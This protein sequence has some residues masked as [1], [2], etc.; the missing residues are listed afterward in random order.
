MSVSINSSVVLGTPDFKTVDIIPQDVARALQVYL[1]R[2]SKLT[3]VSLDDI[4][5][6]LVKRIDDQKKVTLVELLGAGMKIFD[7]I[8]WLTAGRPTTHPLTVDSALSE[9]N[10]TSLHEV[11]RAVFYCYFF[12]ITQARYPVRSNAI[13]EPKTPAFL[14]NLLGMTEKQYHYVNIVCSFEPEKF[15]KSWV[16]YV[17]FKDFGQESLSRFGLGVAGYRLFGPFKLYKPE[18]T[19][20]ESLQAAVDF[21]TKISKSPPT[22]GIHPTTRDPSV[23]TKRGNLNKNLSNLIL[24]V[25]TE[26]QID[27]MVSTKIL[28]QKPSREPNSRNYLQWSRDDDIS[29]NDLIFRN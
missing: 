17:N 25:Y 24:D 22:W 21:A 3:G 20:D 29:G 7:A 15:D 10:I 16:K 14:T 5:T 8:V 11:A 19:Y 4:K 9:K 13:A 27:E 26:T 23:L 2:G 18:K 28:F 6:S 12:I 1:E